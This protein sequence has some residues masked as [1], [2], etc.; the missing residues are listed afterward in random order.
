[1]ALNA[2]RAGGAFHPF[3]KQKPPE[4]A[5]VPA[6]STT[7]PAISAVVGDSG[8]KATSDT[9]VH[10]KDTKDRKEDIQKDKDRE[11]QSQPSRKPRRCWAAELHRK[12]LQALHQLGGPHG[13][14]PR[15]VIY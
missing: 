7:A 8:D 13:W 2:T 11:E 5:D 3:E 14:S 6:S 4:A 1:V 15:F 12:F 10:D 9:E